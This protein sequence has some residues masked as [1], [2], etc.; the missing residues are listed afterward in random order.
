MIVDAVVLWVDGSDQHWQATRQSAINEWSNY[1]SSESN[2]NHRYQD[3]GDVYYC[4]ESV[5]KNAPFVRRVFIVSCGQV[6]PYW[7]FNKERQAAN[8]KI[9]LVHHSEFMPAEHLPTFNSCAIEVNLHKIHGLAKYFL[10]LNDD[11]FVLHPTTLN[12]FMC[13]PKI[14]YFSGPLVLNTSA[15]HSDNFEYQKY[16]NSLAIKKC[17]GYRLRTTPIHQALLLHRDAFERVWVDAADLCEQTSSS[18]FR[19]C[20]GSNNANVNV[21]VFYHAAKG[22]NLT[23]PSKTFISN[24]FAKRSTFSTQDIRS[25]VA[26]KIKLFCLNDSPTHAISNT[27][28]QRAL[29]RIILGPKRAQLPIKRIN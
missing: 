27:Q 16:C 5:L 28:V 24:Y 26:R 6:P 13:G 2:A 29:A 21:Y 7:E 14:R 1:L 10:Y 15:L 17:F 8:G 18:K 4:V 11:M 12:D 9:Q 3:H 22:L 19:T 23:V 20:R 25:V